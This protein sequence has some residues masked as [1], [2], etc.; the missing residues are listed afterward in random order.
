MEDEDPP[1]SRALDR[2]AQRGHRGCGARELVTTDNDDD[3]RKWTFPPGTII[4]A[5]VIHRH[6]YGVRCRPRNATYPHTNFNWYG[7]KSWLGQRLRRSLTR[8]S[9]LQIISV[10]LKFAGPINT[11]PRRR[12]TRPT[13]TSTYLPSRT[14]QLQPRRLYASSVSPNWPPRS[15]R[16]DPL[17]HRR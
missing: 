6:G 11:A 15:R 2:I 4:P 17:H 3:L 16:H 5:G 1:D 9:F 13:L 7:G 14:A 8:L 10:C 12:R